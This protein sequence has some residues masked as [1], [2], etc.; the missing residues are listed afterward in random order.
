MHAWKA[1]NTQWHRVATSTW[2]EYK[3]CCVR[4]SHRSR[5][6]FSIAMAEW[7]CDVLNIVPLLLG[8]IYYIYIYIY[9]C[10][11]YRTN[12][13]ANEPSKY[14][15]RI[16]TTA[17][18]QPSH[19]MNDCANPQAVTCQEIASTIQRERHCLDCAVQWAGLAKHKELI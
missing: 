16:N 10:S 4:H 14:R 5:R 6:L 19:E 15:T 17:L 1:T 13:H 12:I 3:Y 9:S 18:K 2:H 11:D 7:G 8:Q